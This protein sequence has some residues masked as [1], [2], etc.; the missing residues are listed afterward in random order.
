MVPDTYDESATYRW[1]QVLLLVDGWD[2]CPVCLLA[3]DLDLAWY[4]RAMGNNDEETN[5]NAIWILLSNT[6]G[7]RLTLLYKRRTSAENGTTRKDMDQR[8][9][10]P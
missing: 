8:D 2:V 1:D 9:V 5:G 10:H 7:L 4:E 3:D 6:L